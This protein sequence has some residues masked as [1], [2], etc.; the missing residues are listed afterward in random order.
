MAVMAWGILPNA[1]ICTPYRLCTALSP[2]ARRE[3]HFTVG[4]RTGEIQGFESEQGPCAI[5]V[6]E[7][8]RELQRF[9][10]RV[11]GEGEARGVL[12]G[13]GD[14]GFGEGKTGVGGGVIRIER[15]GLSVGGDGAFDVLQIAAAA[16]L[17]RQQEL[18]VGFRAVAAMRIRAHG[19]EFEL[20][21][22][23]HRGGDVV[24]HLK[25]V[26][27]VAIVG[28]R[29]EMHAVGGA[30]QLR[31]HANRAACTAHAALEH[32]RD[33]QGSGNFLQRNSPDS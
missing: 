2:G 6:D 16:E 30:D 29:P 14:G 20:Q 21:G 12:G 4:A 1:A 19:Q 10:G 26:L 28:L 32:V 11:V 23:D 25:D 7:L 24:L 31:G 9:F 3:G 13:V 8:R 27:H 18:V 15:D 5:G 22:C 17:P 33:A